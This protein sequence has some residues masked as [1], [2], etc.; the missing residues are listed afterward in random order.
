MF[1]FPIQNRL[2]CNFET[3]WQF[4]FICYFIWFFGDGDVNQRLLEQIELYEV[5][6]Y[7]S[8]SVFVKFFGDL[9]STTPA[10]RDICRF[11]IGTIFG[12]YEPNN[13]YDVTYHILNSMDFILSY[14]IWLYFLFYLI[15]RLLLDYSSINPCG[16][17]Y[18]QFIHFG[19]IFR[20]GKNFN[21]RCLIWFDSM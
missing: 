6:N 4:V 21:N 2:K 17:S 20:T 9:C 5:N 15:K 11:I 3:C 16:A 8:A 10:L 18:M 19:Q 12:P 13:Y 14:F 1:F 7:S